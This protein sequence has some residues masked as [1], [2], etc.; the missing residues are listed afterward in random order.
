M[1]Q[2]D[3]TTLRHRRSS[4]KGKA[5]ICHSLANRNPPPTKQAA[6]EVQLF[7]TRFFIFLR[8]ESSN[9]F[10]HFFFFLLFHLLFL[11]L[12]QTMLSSIARG[13]HQPSRMASRAFVSTWNNVPQGKPHTPFATFSF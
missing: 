5:K 10:P 6:A 12:P 8:E 3:R 11:L 13:A 7:L 1:G 9:P 2:K 4:K